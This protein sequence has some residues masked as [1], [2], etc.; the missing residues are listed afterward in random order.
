FVLWGE[1]SASQVEV[2]VYPRIPGSVR[3]PVVTVPKGS[4]DVHLVVRRA[5]SL[6]GVVRLDPDVRDN[7]IIAVCSWTESPSNA[8]QSSSHVLLREEER[9]IARI[10]CVGLPEGTV[11]LVLMP[12]DGSPVLRSVSGIRIAGGQETVLDEIDLR[13]I[14]RPIRLTLR[15]SGGV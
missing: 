6:S 12:R 2:R 14:V 3:G 11:T 1:S 4:R 10:H 13:G 8:P 9:G 15:D 5:G 7:S